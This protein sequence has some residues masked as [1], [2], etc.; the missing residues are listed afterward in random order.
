MVLSTFSVISGYY[1][2]EILVGVG[3]PM[4][5]G[6]M[7]EFVNTPATML[8]VEWAPDW[9]KVGLM[10]LTLNCFAFP[11]MRLAFELEYPNNDA[12]QYF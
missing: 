6:P 5:P 12:S 8:R 9:F 1:L 7:A 4:F 10:C 2:K 3:S 11:Q